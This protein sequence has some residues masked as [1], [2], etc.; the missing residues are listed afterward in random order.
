MVSWGSATGCGA[1][2]RWLREAHAP[3][4]VAALAL[5][6]LACVPTPRGHIGQPNGRQS[7]TEAR[8]AVEDR[9][10]CALD[11]GQGVKIEFVEIPAGS[12]VMGVDDPSRPQDGP[13]HV[14]H[15]PRSFYMSKYE[16]TQEQWTAVMGHN[17]SRF[18]GDPRL[19]VE[20]VSWLECQEFCEK[21]SR[22]AGGVVQLPL[23]SEWEYA[24]RAGT[25]TPFSFGESLSLG[26]ARFSPQTESRPEGGIGADQ[27]TAPVGSL[28]PN[29]WGLHDMHGNVEEWC[30]DRLTVY[31]QHV[32]ATLPSIRQWRLEDRA[33]RGGCWWMGPDDCRSDR[34]RMR[35]ADARDDSLGFRVVMDGDVGARRQAATAPA[36]DLYDVLGHE[37]E[38]HTLHFQT[39]RLSTTQPACKLK[40]LTIELVRYDPEAKV[41]V[42]RISGE[43]GVLAAEEGRYFGSDKSLRLDKVSPD[44]IEIKATWCD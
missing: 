20:S 16:V 1:D 31:T 22:Q 19:P 26:Q 23:E 38:T 15:V 10:T 6:G 25:V 11:I 33:T 43:D 3:A 13:C 17:P 44:G 37:P 4:A 12:F 7:A 40:G 34:R 32:T 35:P 30:I 14:V 27:G 42:V 24:C 5:M 2:R 9:H 29:H 41:A 28:A 36:T 39:G 8:T 18:R 21:L